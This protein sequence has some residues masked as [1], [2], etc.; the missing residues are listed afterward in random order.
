MTTPRD[1]FCLFAWNYRQLD[2]S[3]LTLFDRF[4]GGFEPGFLWTRVKWSNYSAI[5]A[6]ATHAL[7][8]FILVPNSG[9]FGSLIFKSRLKNSEIMIRNHRSTRWGV[10]VYGCGSKIYR[11]YCLHL[12][13]NYRSQAWAIRRSSIIYYLLDDCSTHSGPRLRQIIIVKLNSHWIR[14][15]VVRHCAILHAISHDK[16]RNFIFT[17][18]WNS[19][20]PGFSLSVWFLVSLPYGTE[21]DR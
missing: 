3:L 20:H 2:N 19:Q 4:E 12:L 8:L 11:H 10:I 6:L 13:R 21:T 1:S 5:P 15:D 14:H 16:T 17:Y 9:W 7:A 18:C